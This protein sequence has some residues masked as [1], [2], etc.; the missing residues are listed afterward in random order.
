MVSENKPA[1]APRVLVV[2]DEPAIRELVTRVFARA[3]YIVDSAADGQEA[4]DKLA[5]DPGYSV[6]VLDLT[7]PRRSGFDVIEALKH[8][9]PDGLKGVI[10]TTALD[11]KLRQSDRT[12]V[13]G[14][15]RKPFD[16]A[17]LKKRVQACL[18][19]CVPEP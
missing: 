5:G 4:L 3:D 16:L 10:V 11:R 2:E 17:D 14:I 15:V 1:N 6:V 19:R 9:H 13:C 12:V 18:D 7:M 8:E